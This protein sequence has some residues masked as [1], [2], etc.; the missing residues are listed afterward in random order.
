MLYAVVKDGDKGGVAAYRID[1]STGELTILNQQ[2]GKDR[3]LA[4]SVWIK[5]TVMFCPPITTTGRSWH[6]L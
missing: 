2:T 1:G 5:I 3:R 4:T 6:I